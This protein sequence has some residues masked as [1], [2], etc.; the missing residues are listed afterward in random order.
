MNKKIIILFALFISLNQASFAG[1]FSITEKQEIKVGQDASKQVDKTN[2]ILKDDEINDYISNLGEK[3]VGYSDRENLKYRFKIINTKDINA[4]ALPGGYVY[5][6]RGLIESADNESELV[7]V[8]AHEIGHIDRRHSVKQ[9]E[10]AKKAQTG[11]LVAGIAM[12]IAGFGGTNTVLNGAELVT[13]GVFLKFSR[14]MEREADQTAT[15]LMYSAGWDPKGMVTFFEKLAKKGNSAITFLS[16][17]PSPQER[18]ENVDNL[19][20]E[21]VDGKKK[22]KKDSD[23]FH[24]IKAE[25]AEI[26][27]PKKKIVSP[28]R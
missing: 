8:I 10:K 9:I 27:L 7:G 19:I 28:Y 13:Q 25:L 23:E 21:L 1:I 17:H 20:D 18:K 12:S 11:F 2:P 4:F 15:E 24:R 22:L 5:I 14:D 6:Y 26:P 3:L 16:T